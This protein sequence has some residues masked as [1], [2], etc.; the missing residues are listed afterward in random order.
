MSSC[1]R[2]ATPDRATST[3]SLQLVGRPQGAIV[4]LIDLAR[5]VGVGEQRA[6]LVERVGVWVVERRRERQRGRSALIATTMD[7]AL[8]RPEADPLALEAEAFA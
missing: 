7:S 3:W 4:R 6:G 5:A 8:E 1:A 2:S